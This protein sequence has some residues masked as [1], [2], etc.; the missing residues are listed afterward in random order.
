MPR[1]TP[2]ELSVLRALVDPQLSAAKNIA[3]SLGISV[4]MVKL[5]VFRIGTK[6][7]WGGGSQRVLALWAIAHREQLGIELPTAAQFPQT[8]SPGA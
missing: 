5:Y 8:D 6:L 2:R 4:G 1:L 7:G 3:F